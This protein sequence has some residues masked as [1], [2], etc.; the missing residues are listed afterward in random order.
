MEESNRECCQPACLFAHHLNS[1]T[2]DHCWLCDLAIE[3]IEK[4]DPSTESAK[5]RALIRHTAKDM[6]REL[7]EHQCQPDRGRPK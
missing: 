1:Q 2:V 6:A 3:K 5:H 4:V 7:V